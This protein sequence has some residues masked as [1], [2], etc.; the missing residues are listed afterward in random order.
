M[1][2]FL[3]KFIFQSKNMIRSTKHSRNRSTRISL[4]II[5]Y[6]LIT[7]VTLN[8]Q[9]VV[10]D[11]DDIEISIPSKTA[12]KRNSY[13]SINGGIQHPYMVTVAM[14][15]E[16]TPSENYIEETELKALAEGYSFGIGLIKKPKSFL[17]VG[18]LADFYNSIVP[19]TRSGERSTSLWVL[20]KNKGASIYTVPFE[21]AHDRVSDV[22]TIRG[23]IRLKLPLGPINVWAAITGGTYSSS[24]RFTDQD[25]TTFF[26]STSKTLIAPSYMAGLDLVIRNNQ[27]KDVLSFTLFADFSS[28]RMEEKFFDVVIPGWDFAVPE[29]NNVISPVRFG[30]SVGIHL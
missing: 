12:Q 28:P 3:T 29:G 4:L 18:I 1:C 22:I 2:H 6:M 20:E 19:I 11:Q 24:V 17:E 13:L 26:N 23:I 10:Y 5:S 7:T 27:K 8:A 15:P 14:I 9:G 21:E 25:E 30:L 16:S